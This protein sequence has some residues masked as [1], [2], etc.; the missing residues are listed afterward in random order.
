MAFF[1]I[2][3]VFVLLILIGLDWSTM[4][5]LMGPNWK[6]WNEIPVEPYRTDFNVRGDYLRRSLTIPPRVTSSDPVEL[7]DPYVEYLIEDER[8]DE[9]MGYINWMVKRGRD[10]RDERLHRTGMIYR[11][12]LADKMASAE[13]RDREAI[14]ELLK[15][16][17]EA[18]ETRR[19]SREQE[20]AIASAADARVAAV[21]K[22]RPHF[23]ELNWKSIFY[24]RQSA[25]PQENTASSKGKDNGT[26]SGT[27]DLIR[28]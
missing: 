22:S 10:N 13:K 1:W 2:V 18:I 27:D 14:R 20:S 6:W 8:F 19:I 23:L 7:P 15:E 24:G 4:R 28:V 26:E 12:R 3:I 9:A 11:A 16:R 25:P 21:E 5:M 17:R